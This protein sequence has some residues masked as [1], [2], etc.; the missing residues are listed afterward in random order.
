VHKGRVRKYLRALKILSTGSLADVSIGTHSRG[1][2]EMGHMN[3]FISYSGYAYT[4]TYITHMCINTCT[5]Y[6]R[7]MHRHGWSDGIT[8]T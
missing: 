3:Q 7:P 1:V 8:H 5:L 6:M 4:C 2:L